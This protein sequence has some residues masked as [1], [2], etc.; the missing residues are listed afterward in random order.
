MM[1]WEKLESDPGLLFEVVTTLDDHVSFNRYLKRLPECRQ[2]LRNGL[3]AY[4]KILPLVA[5]AACFAMLAVLKGSA[6]DLE[7][8]LGEGARARFYIIVLAA[9]AAGDALAYLALVG[10]RR[11]NLADSLRAHLSRRT[12]VDPSDPQLAERNAVVLYANGFSVATEDVSFAAA[13]TTIRRFDEVAD[14]FFIMFDITR[15]VIIPKR[16]LPPATI[17]AIRDM[18]LAFRKVSRA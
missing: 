4:G 12:G 9:L 2:R 16:E 3:I 1:R 5:I 11:A 7:E 8:A 14:H 15:G 6:C 17:L 18:M 13:W 10:M